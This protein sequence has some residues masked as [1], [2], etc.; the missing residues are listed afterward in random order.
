MSSSDTTPRTAPPASTAPASPTPLTDKLVRTSHRDSLILT[1][2][3]TQD[4]A[5]IG[6]ERQGVLRAGTW[7]MT[8]TYSA[9]CGNGA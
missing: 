8:G 6:P 9:L 2:R 5:G 4:L 7:Q 1:L 3:A